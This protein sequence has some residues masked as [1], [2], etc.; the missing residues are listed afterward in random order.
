VEEYNGQNP[1]L[2]SEPLVDL[3]S[4]L[5][6]VCLL[7]LTWYRLFRSEPAKDENDIQ[8]LQELAHWYLNIHKYAQTFLNT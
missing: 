4:E 6:D 3:S 8:E 2:G 5:I 1:G 7:L